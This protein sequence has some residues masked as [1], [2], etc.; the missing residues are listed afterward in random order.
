MADV[1]IKAI[2]LTLLSLIIII[3]NL[4]VIRV[5]FRCKRLRTPKNYYIL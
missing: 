4:M 1:I 3:E 2:F 5:Y